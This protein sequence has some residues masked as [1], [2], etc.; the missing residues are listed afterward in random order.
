VPPDALP[1]SGTLFSCQGLRVGPW[2]PQPCMG[3]SYFPHNG[4]IGIHLYC[5]KMHPCLADTEC[6]ICDIRC[7]AS[8]HTRFVALYCG[9]IAGAGSLC[10]RLWYPSS[11]DKP[12]GTTQQVTALRTRLE[13]KCL[14]QGHRSFDPA[15]KLVGRGQVVILPDTY[16]GTADPGPINNIT[17]IILFVS[18]G[19]PSMRDTA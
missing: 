6:T 17:P 1:R 13:L 12:C 18:C 4:F 7:P 19:S 5:V 14:K 15:I 3:K 2:L 11:H 8:V 10:S 16:C 9:T